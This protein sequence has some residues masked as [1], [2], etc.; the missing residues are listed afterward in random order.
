[1]SITDLNT[2]IAFAAGLISFFSPCVLPLVPAYLA[3]MGARIGVEKGQDEVIKGR[4]FLMTL[5]FIL[6]FTVV[7]ILLGVSF[8]L[9][10]NFLY[11]YRVLLNRI[12]GIVVFAFGLKQLGVLRISFLERSF[13]GIWKAPS[14]RGFFS[15]FILGMIFSLGWS[16]CAGPVLASILVLAMGTG[17]PSTAAFYLF[18]YSMGLALPFIM[19]AFFWE[20]ILVRIKKLHRYLPL[21]TVI[22]AVLLIILGVMLFSGLFL[23][24]AAILA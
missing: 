19:M 5:A 20:R 18:A 21:F 15:L 17:S 11:A 10:G 13:G 6:G 7:F 4:V 22:S 12:G 16:P 2:G 14:S 8:G 9:I 1:M 23:K 3:S 24:V